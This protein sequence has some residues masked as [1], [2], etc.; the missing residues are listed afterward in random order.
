MPFNSLTDFFFSKS[1]ESFSEMS[2]LLSIGY[3]LD[4]YVGIQYRKFHMLVVHLINFGVM[5]YN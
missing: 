1:I 4:V 5:L 2:A 3:T